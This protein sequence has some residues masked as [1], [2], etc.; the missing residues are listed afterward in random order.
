MDVT[1]CETAA[2]FLDATLEY[3][4]RDPLRT[5]VMGSVASSVARG[6]AFQDE[7]YW[8]V[9][10]DDDDDV[11]GA[12]MRTPPHPLA[13]GP[14]PDVALAAVARAVVEVD[15]GF[16]AV[17][18]FGVEAFLPAYA[19]TGTPG[20]ARAVVATQRQVLYVCDAVEAPEVPGAAVLAGS[21][22]LEL[23]RRW[24]RDFAEEIDGL[25]ASDDDTPARASLADGRLRWWRV[26]DETVSMAGHA[27]P[28]E[29]PG[30]T[31]ARVGPVFTPPASRGHGYAAG[32]T[33]HLTAELLARGA[34]VMLFADEA[35]PTSNGV[36][37]RLGYREVDV[38]VSVR[39]G[40]VP[41]R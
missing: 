7:A 2:G 24:Y 10:R 6:V 3:R 19:A 35:N 13:L 33:G 20:A 21:Q 11:V 4:A 30:G 40:P 38:A 31:V 22:D 23:A 12:A 25:R 29:V 1:R 8:W 16:T 37:R 27:V 32:V 28:I 36:Y 39:L 17:N 41:G 9:V 15:D 5:N 26:G 34:T 18:G 14:M